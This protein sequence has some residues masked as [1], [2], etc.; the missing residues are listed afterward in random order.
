MVWTSFGQLVLFA[1]QMASQIVVARHLNPYLMGI[2]AIAFSISDFVNLMQTFGLRNFLVRETAIDADV[3]AS[4][5]TI[6]FIMSVLTSA[7]VLVMALGGSALYHEPRVREVLLVVALIPLVSSFELVPGGLLQRHMAFGLLAI[8]SASRAAVTAAVSITM[9]LLG[10]SYM[11]ISYG[12]LCGALVS[13]ALTCLFGRRFMS[14]RLS[15]RHWRRITRFGTHMLSISGVSNVAMKSVDLIIG[16]MLGLASLGLFSRASA[17]N[18]VLWS[19]IHSVFTKVVFSSMAEEK[20][21]TGSIR[22]I[23]L[24][25]I[26]LV[27]ATLWPA[28]AGLAVLSGP[29][30]YL[31]YGPKWVAAAPILSIFAIAAVGLTATTMAWEVFVVEERTAEQ[32]RIETLRAVL[33]LIVTVVGASIGI[34]AAAC[35][36]IADAGITFALYRRRLNA[37]TGTNNAEIFKIY[38]R[39][40]VLTLAAI[41]PAAALMQVYGWSPRVPIYQVMPAAMAGIALWAGLAH[42][43]NRQLADEMAVFARKV[44]SR[45]KRQT[46]LTRGDEVPDTPQ[47]PME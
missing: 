4:T 33:S 3:V 41:L 44:R 10:A 11:S 32:T 1:S 37:L 42:V 43:L 18:N 6:N 47:V 15:F 17:L 21:Q 13:A 24:H 28:F 38:G 34:L 30:V 7:L 35:G 16:R 25:T 5:F 22:N 27:T 29:L 2:S 14:W 12:A 36:R 40:I 23:Y 9:V 46:R 8:A 26:N 39:N 45:V 19:N 31:M 20:R